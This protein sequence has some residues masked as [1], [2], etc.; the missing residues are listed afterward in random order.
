MWRLGWFLGAALH[1]PER[2]QGSFLS[3]NLRLTAFPLDLGGAYT[4]VEVGA[5]MVLQ[6]SRL[7][8]KC[9]LPFFLVSILSE[10]WSLF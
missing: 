1:V 7:F 5:A 10:S 9:I 3:C 2:L 8:F 6:A 4:R